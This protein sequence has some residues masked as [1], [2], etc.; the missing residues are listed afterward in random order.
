MWEADPEKRLSMKEVV[1]GL[2]GMQARAGGQ[3]GAQWRAW[4]AG[5]MMLWRAE[6]MMLCVV[7]E[8]SVAHKWGL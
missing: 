2:R 4:W 8:R 3:G 6:C 1:L 5:C 7:V